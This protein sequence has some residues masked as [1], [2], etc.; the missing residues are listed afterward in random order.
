MPNTPPDIAH[1]ESKLKE[2][3]ST[4]EESSYSEESGHPEPGAQDSLTATPQGHE[5]E[6]DPQDVAMEDVGNDPT[7]LPPSEQDDDPLPVTTQTTPS[8]SLLEGDS[9]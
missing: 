1:I 2:C 5:E 3:K 7:P 4:D 8:G 6:E 9:G